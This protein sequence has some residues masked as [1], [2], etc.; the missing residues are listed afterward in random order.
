MHI[1]IVKF[2]RCIQFSWALVFVVLLVAN[3]GQIQAGEQIVSIRED[4]ASIEHDFS[5]KEQAQLLAV[6]QESLKVLPASL[7]EDRKKAL[8]RFLA[9][10]YED[11]VLSYSTLAGRE[12]QES[13]W[14][15]QVNTQALL[16][17]L[18]GI[19]VYYTGSR[20]LAY[21]LQI[22]DHGHQAQ[23]IIAHLEL[24][25]G[26]VQD[27]V[28]YPLL[29]FESVADGMWSAV[30]ESEQNT[31][32]AKGEKLADVWQKL[33]AEYF[34]SPEGMKPFVHSMQL[35]MKGW[36]SMSAVSGFSKQLKEWHQ[37]VDRAVL[38]QVLV[39]GGGLQ[40]WWTILSPEPKKLNGR[41][42]SYTSG[43]GLT[44]KLKEEKT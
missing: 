3:Q 15:V 24:L 22:M 31:W 27:S 41:L 19:G 29:R 4:V 30:L 32:R 43:L 7:D 16:G 12:D 14:R 37:V 38:D 8:H 28:L 20:P 18:K 10:R 5:G 11:Y 23:Q 26:C 35:H 34:S 17:L 1:H 25:S 39:Q 21:R 13:A 42:D 33:W 9:S 2:S 6:F 44:W 36:S 40:G